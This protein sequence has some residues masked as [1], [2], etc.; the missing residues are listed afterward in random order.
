[1]FHYM[2]DLKATVPSATLVLFKWLLFMFRF[3]SFEI[4]K[5][6]DLMTGRRG[7]S[8]GRKDI[9]IKLLDYVIKTFYPQVGPCFSKILKYEFSFPL[10]GIYINIYDTRREIK[11]SLKQKTMKFHSLAVFSLNNDSF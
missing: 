6:A 10:S 4:V 3:G 7:P 9:L 5:Q 1:M 8:A 2:K 11:N